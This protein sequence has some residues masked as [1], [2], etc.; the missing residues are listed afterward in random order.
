[1]AYQMFSAKRTTRAELRRT[2]NSNGPEYLKQ[3]A[4]QCLD[5]ADEIAQMD[6][7]VPLD[8]L[9]LL[10]PQLPAASPAAIRQRSWVDILRSSLQGVR[11]GITVQCNLWIPSEDDTHR[12][13]FGSQSLAAVQFGRIN[14]HWYLDGSE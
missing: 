10:P 7:L 5:I 2:A 9:P 4:Q 14:P 12:S 6:L 11:P 3:A 13:L 8:L 1:M